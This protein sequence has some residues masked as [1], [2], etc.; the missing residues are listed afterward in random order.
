M[1][2]LKN[3][4]IHARIL[5]AAMG[6]ITASTFILGYFGLD[7]VKTLVSQR[8]DRQ[9]DYM[10]EHLA[11]NAE[12]GILID[13]H[14][15]LNA[16]A[17]SVLNE[18]DVVGV[19]IEDS[20][21]R[22]LAEQTRA[23]R[24]AFFITEKKVH[25]SRMETD[26]TDLEIISGS[27]DKTDIGRVRIKYTREG[28]KDLTTAMAHR[29]MLLSLGL[30]VASCLIF[31]LISRSLV[32]PVISLAEVAHQVSQGNRSLRAPLGTLPETRRL[33]LSF[34]E[35][36]DS[37]EVARQALLDAQVKLSRQ[38]A[39]AEVGKF[40]MMIAHE[41]KNPLAIIKSSLDM[42]K[43]DLNIPHDNL[44]LNY[45]EEELTRLNEL[46]ESFLMFARPTK[47]KMVATNLNHLVEQVALGFQLQYSSDTLDIKYAIPDKE[48]I[49]LADN[50]LLSRALSNIIRNACDAS[51]NQG[52]IDIDVK[53]SH[54]FWTVHVLDYGDG[55][56]Q[57]DLKNMFEPFYTTKAT[58]TG[59]GLAFADQVVKAHGGTITASSPRDEGALF[60]MEIPLDNCT[61]KHKDGI[62]N[63][64]YSHR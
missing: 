7:M 9:I 44:L 59:L 29:F 14:S 24:G 62:A 60:C 47:P 30:A 15:L 16:L 39:L 25:M 34:N 37:M 49:A 5:V 46:I 52:N 2:C 36:L 20:N 58:G 42:L 4:G 45:T 3:I 33:A 11:T 10:A 40:S 57:K 61:T 63:G 54:N 28:I 6:I 56:D 53:I 41:V 8:F 12:L 38:E 17:K 32:L 13:E 22:R 51:R 31:F 21:G 43:K 1:N 50:D 64:T 23:G 55:I 35:M 19:E 18:K 27:K 48:C 26:S